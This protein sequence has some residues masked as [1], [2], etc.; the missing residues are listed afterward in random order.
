MAAGAAVL[1]GS[2][3]VHA[4][5]FEDASRASAFMAAASVCKS[6]VSPEKR[7]EMYSDILRIYNTPSQVKYVI[8]QEVG[9]LREMSPAEREAMCAALA[10]QIKASNR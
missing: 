5:S 10:D 8:D 6:E 7:R 9:T 1:L 3:S 4:A 2:V